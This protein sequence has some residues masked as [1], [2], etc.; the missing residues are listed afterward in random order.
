MAKVRATI[1]YEDWFDGLTDGEAAAV[2]KAVEK[3]QIL[4][5]ELGF[6]NSSALEGSRKLRELRVS[7]N[8]IRVF[9]AF[10]PARSAVL[11]LG[12]SKAGR[13]KKRFYREMIVR[14]EALLIVYVGGK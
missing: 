6:P 13:N 3:L 10:D 14:C 12:A 4:G 8:A 11:L 9:Y 1:E 2:A 5:T 7:K